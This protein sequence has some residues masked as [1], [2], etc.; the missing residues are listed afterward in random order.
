[1]LSPSIALHSL[2]DNGANTLPRAPTSG[3]PDSLAQPRTVPSCTRL[4]KSR[5]SPLFVLETLAEVF[6]PG[7]RTGLLTAPNPS[8]PFLHQNL[9]FRRDRQVQ[10]HSGQSHGD[11]RLH[12]EMKVA[13]HR[14]APVCPA[15]QQLVNTVPGLN[16]S[17]Q[18]LTKPITDGY[19]AHG[20]GG[21][22]LTLQTRVC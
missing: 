14:T 8:Y 2:K 22:T 9:S 1:M 12:C 15:S 3:L 6:P 20:V 7:R 5:L 11:M 16:S 13:A 18:P 10:H 17:I 21:I 19:D 4:S